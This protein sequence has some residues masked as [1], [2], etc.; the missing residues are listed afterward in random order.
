MNLNINEYS[1]A[2]ILK[3]FS[4]ELQE[5]VLLKE[6][7]KRAYRKCCYLHPDKSGLSN[8]YFIFYTRALERL[9][10]IYRTLNSDEYMKERSMADYRREN[11]EMKQSEDL[12]GGV[13]L[14]LTKREDFSQIFNKAFES[15]KMADP[16]QDSGYS[17]WMKQ[18]TTDAPA[19]SNIRDMHNAIAERKRVLIQTRGNELA[20]IQQTMSSS[21]GAASLMREQPVEYSS[22]P[23]SKLKYEDL[24]KAHTETL[25]PVDETMARTTYTS[26]DE[27][28]RAR[29]EGMVADAH[30]LEEEQRAEL[31]RQEEQQR[32]RYI[33]QQ[34]YLSQQE[35]LAK[36]KQ[37]GWW[38]SLLQLTGR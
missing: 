27:Y 9:K 32:Q 24:R 23:F 25:I 8:D 1:D 3:L 13:A 36:E 30:R 21:M 19:V 20:T 33:Q 35:E 15:A 5:G 31:I 18:T 38:N 29:N 16:E 2:D 6:D 17:D 14:N 11:K 12:Y 4:I 37:A 10:R 7:V 28:E 34:K 26:V 22:D